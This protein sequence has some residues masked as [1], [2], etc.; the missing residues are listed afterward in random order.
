[1]DNVLE[2]LTE[3]SK[4]GY[5]TTEFWMSLAALVVTTLISSGA[6]PH[7]GALEKIIGG[8]SV[9]LLALGYNVGRTIVKANGED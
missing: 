9:V 5:K 4:P 6:I 2:K 3:Q 7:D 1:M 8:V